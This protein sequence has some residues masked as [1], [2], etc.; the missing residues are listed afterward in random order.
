MYDGCYYV[1]WFVW[2]AC[3]SLLNVDDCVY[4]LVV[5]VL[6]MDVKDCWL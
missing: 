2:H 1:F 3:G 4:G 6:S 5:S